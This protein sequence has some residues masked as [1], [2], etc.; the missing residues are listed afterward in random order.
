MRMRR[1]KERSKTE[2]REYEKI[3]ENAEKYKV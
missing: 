2:E 1:K 3:K